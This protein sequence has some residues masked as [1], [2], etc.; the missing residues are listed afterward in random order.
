MELKVKK[1]N[2]NAKLP[3]YAHPGDAGMDL[4]AA[5]ATTI[6][7]RG[8]GLVP[9]GIALAVPDGYVGL[10]WDKS[11]VPA[12]YGVTKMSGVLDSGYRGEIKLVLY[13]TSDTDCTFEVGQ[14]VAQLLIQPVIQPQIIE[15]EELDTTSRGAGGFGST[16]K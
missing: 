15:V 10:V 11:S 8:R 12:N 6:P 2:P 14:K 13:N 5:E 4:Y 1:L 3:T 7:A 16:G 9:T